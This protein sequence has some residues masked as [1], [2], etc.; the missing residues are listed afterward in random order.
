VRVLTPASLLDRM[1]PRLP[2]LHGGAMDQPAR[3]QTM[4]AAFA[5]RV[6]WMASGDGCARGFAIRSGA[7]ARRRQNR[8]RVADAQ[9]PPEGHRDP[10]TIIPSPC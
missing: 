2:L 7:S 3:L 6:G 10:I 4:R 1:E 9:S 5:N 8:S